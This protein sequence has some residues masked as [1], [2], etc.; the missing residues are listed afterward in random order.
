MELENNFIPER[1]GSYTS[2]VL[3]LNSKYHQILPKKQSIFTFSSWKISFFCFCL[4]YLLNYWF[5]KIQYSY[6]LSSILTLLFYEFYSLFYI[7]LK[8]NS[9]SYVDD[10]N[11]VVSLVPIEDENQ[12]ANI[13][14]A[15][16]LIHIRKV[17]INENKLIFF[18]ITVTHKT[19]RW[20]VWR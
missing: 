7:K 12:M 3:C 5:K 14:V 10:K 13:N 18:R 4:G 8:T 20:H 16:C 11:K 17:K 9:S 2:G 15:N 19:L 1:Y 6:F